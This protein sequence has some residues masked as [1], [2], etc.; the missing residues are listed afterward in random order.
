M[1]TSLNH[2]PRALV[3]C[4]VLGAAAL[5]L[6]PASSV[7]RAQDGAPASSSAPAASPQK[8]NA[9]P[10]RQLLVK[11]RELLE[12]K[13]SSGEA[14]VEAD[15]GEDGSLTNVWVGGT[16]DRDFL[17][18]ADE[19]ARAINDSRV[20]SVFAKDA[21]HVRM[22]LRLGPEQVEA[23]AA[24]DTISAER[25]NEL[26]KGY[27][28]MLWVARQRAA[29]RPTFPVWN[30]VRLSANGK[31]LVIQLEMPREQVGNLLHQQITPN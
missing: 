6:L 25:A 23:F 11:F 7:A 21:R 19:A 29:D 15:L 8:I 13:E 30:S 14:S 22:R 2:V 24:L 4:L 28:G 26:A 27:G 20:L 10:L 3:R 5:S 16:A 9:L 31:Q 17:R 18:F 1:R 12:R